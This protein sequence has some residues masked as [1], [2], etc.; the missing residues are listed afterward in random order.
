MEE[1]S[2]K[3]DGPCSSTITWIKFLALFSEKVISEA[4]WS[5]DLNIVFMVCKYETWRLQAARKQEPSW[6][7]CHPFIPQEDSNLNGN[8]RIQEDS[9]LHT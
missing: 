1:E 5:D 3:V 7:R 9:R 2:K 4:C 8:Y 6:I